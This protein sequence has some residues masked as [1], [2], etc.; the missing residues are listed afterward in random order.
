MKVLGIDTSC[1]DTSI[2]VY[3]GEKDKVLSNVV[4]SQHEFHQPFGGIVPEIAARKHAENIDLVF[5]ES[6]QIAGIETKDLDLITV[7]RTPGLLPALLVGLTFGKG[8]SYCLSLPLKT[9]HH[10]EAHIYSPFIEKREEI[11]SKFLALVVS[12]GHT[13][14]LLVEH[15]FKYTLIGKTL[16]DAVGEAYDKV[17]QMLNLGYPGGPIIDKIYRNYS[18]EYVQLPKP[19]VEG[20]NYSFSGLKSAVKRLTEKGYPKEQLAASFQKTAIEYL[21]SKL[22]KAI[23]YY[24]IEA[25]AISGGVSANSLLRKKLQELK[26]EGKKIFL[27]DMEY[28]S[29]NGAMVAFVGYMKYLLEGEDPLTISAAAR[30]ILNSK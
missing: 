6:L 27:P 26:E 29:D 19:K 23:D 13:L 15:P 8:L 1:D 7:T 5:Q 3:E 22:K 24:K 25:I 28:T 16:D 17:A 10:I 21:L 2:A 12:G 14:L 4:S 9:V 11:P 30:S 20:F 18:G